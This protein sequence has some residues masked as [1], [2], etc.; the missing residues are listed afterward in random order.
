MVLVSEDQAGD[1][2][3]RDLHICGTVYM[4]ILLMQIQ[5]Y[6]FDKTKENQQG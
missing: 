6:T 5:L 1:R 2:D 4:H 3:R